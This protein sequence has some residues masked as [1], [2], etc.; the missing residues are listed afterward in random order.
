MLRLSAMVSN[1]ERDFAQVRAVRRKAEGSPMKFYEVKKLEVGA[2]GGLGLTHGVYLDDD[3][4]AT[5]VA[6]CFSENAARE[7]CAA[8]MAVEVWLACCYPNLTEEHAK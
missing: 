8:L 6:L 2:A 3:G 1:A 7:I 4:M 5:A